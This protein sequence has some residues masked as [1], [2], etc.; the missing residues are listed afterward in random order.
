MAEQESVWNSDN[1]EHALLFEIKLC[2]ISNMKAWD[3]ENAYW[4]IRLLRVEIDAKLDEKEQDK[5]SDD[6]KALEKLRNEYL[7]SKDNPEAVGKFY[8]ELETVYILISRLFK[9]HGIYYRSG[10]DP[11]RAALRR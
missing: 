2:F 7:L 1:M 6:L 11:S 4:D 10:L 8:A 3:L 9:K 5:L